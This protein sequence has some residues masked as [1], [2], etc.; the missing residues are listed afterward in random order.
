MMFWLR[1]LIIV[2]MPSMGHAATYTAAA[3]TGTADHTKVQTAVDSATDGDTVQIQ[4][5]NCTF[6]APVAWANKAIVVQ[7]AGISSTTITASSG[8]FSITPTTT[9]GWRITA[10]TISSATSGAVIDIYAFNV[11]APLASR[12]RIDHLTMAMTSAGSPRGVNVQGMVYGLIDHVTVTSVIGTAPHMVEVNAQS[13][14]D[15][16]AGGGLAGATSMALALDLGGDTAVYV[17]DST[18]SQPFGG[19]GAINNITYGGRMVMRHNTYTGPVHL[20][21]HATR[22]QERGGMKSEYY[23]NV[24][25]GLN[26][27]VYP[28]PAN[29]IAGTGVMFN[30]TIKNADSGATFTRFISMLLYFQRCPDGA[31]VVNSAPTTLCSSSSGYDGGVEANGWPCLDQPGHIGGTPGSQSSVPVYLWNNGVEDGC[32]TGG[33]CSADRG[34]GINCGGSMANYIKTTVHSNGAKDYC[35]GT[36]TMPGS[37]G[38]HTNTYTPYTY[39]HP[40]QGVTSKSRIGGGSRFMGGSKLLHEPEWQLE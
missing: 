39:P 2:L 3:C 9:V 15:N 34:I 5:G 25:D 12:F 29:I 30:N 19:Y 1:C 38:T 40:L 22:G 10:M 20:Q 6:T 33:A 31:C 16:Y 32:S 4:A 24:H 26:D 17:E 13:I 27:T 18:Y 23:N 7:G 28:G 21:T 8:A 35:V 14:T 36:T 11:T 37:C